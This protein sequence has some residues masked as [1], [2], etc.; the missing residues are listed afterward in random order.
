ML[1]EAKRRGYLYENPAEE[2][3]QLEE[4]PKEKSILSIDEVKELFRED[5]I[6]RVW[7]GDRIHFTLNLLSAS[8][9]IRMGAVQALKVGKVHSKYVSIHHSWSRK[10][11]IRPPKGNSLR[12]IPIPFKTSKHLF[13]LIELSP[14][15]EPDDLVFWCI[16]RYTPIRNE[17]ILK[18]LYQAFEKI[19]I[20]SKERKGKNIT[21]HSWRHFYNSLL[22]GKIHDSKLQRLTGHRTEKMTDHYT[23]FSIDDFKDVLLIQEQYFS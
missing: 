2:I 18:V 9:G 16:D 17:T 12:E 22:R 14:Y 21:F 11:G 6:D 1:K 4:Q 15:Q 20:S 19:G 8:T 7:G 23:H 10:Y 3:E 13:E 5:H